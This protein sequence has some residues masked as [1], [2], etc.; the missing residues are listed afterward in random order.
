MII[1]IRSY[2]FNATIR[3]LDVS[4]PGGR[5]QRK[6]SRLRKEPTLMG[7]AAGRGGTDAVWDGSVL[8]GTI[9]AGTWAGAARAGATRAGARSVCIGKIGSGRTCGATMALER[10]KRG[11]GHEGGAANVGPIVCRGGACC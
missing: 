1:P 5:N 11:G 4:T 2:S 3:C 7:L 9:L 10:T 6:I 8:A